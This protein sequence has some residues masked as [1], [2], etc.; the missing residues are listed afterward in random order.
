MKRGMYLSLV[1]PGAEE[2]FE[3][4]VAAS[5][6]ERRRA[7][8]GAGVVTFSAF[9]H[10][11]VVCVYFETTAGRAAFEWEPAAGEWLESWPGVAGARLAVPMIDIFHDGDPV[12]ISSWRGDRQVEKRA[13]ALARLKPDMFAS[14]VFYHFQLQ[15]ETPESFNKT[16]TIGTHESF[17]FSYCEH[18]GVVSDIKPKGLLDTSNTPADWHEVMGP[19]FDRWENAAEG[20]ELWVPMKSLFEF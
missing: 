18:P 11:R 6:P 1:K 13:G 15:E 4:F 7:L 20:Q 17:I 9:R 12:D 2:A 10:D 19:H 3:R 5:G 14:Y 8:E 16:Y